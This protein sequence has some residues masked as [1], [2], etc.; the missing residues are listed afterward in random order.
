MRD[1]PKLSGRKGPILILKIL[2]GGAGNLRVSLHMSLSAR[3]LPMP[4]QE[5]G[6]AGVKQLLALGD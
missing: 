6:K 4:K 3:H 1:S 5:A 2:G